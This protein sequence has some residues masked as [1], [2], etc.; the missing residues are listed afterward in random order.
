MNTH[1]KG[2]E[3]LQLL[4]V[5][6][7]KIKINILIITW[8][9]CPLHYSQFFDYLT[10]QDHQDESVDEFLNASC[11]DD[12]LHYCCPKC[13]FK[14]RISPLFIDHVANVHPKA[15]GILE[16]ITSGN[17]KKEDIDPAL[18][19][20]QDLINYDLGKLISRKI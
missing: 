13:D 15:K 6:L 3:H 1:I 16:E 19:D 9:K 4:H 12:F 14:C 2:L 5:I 10:L 8:T 17:K 11:L 7:S 18:E 20:V